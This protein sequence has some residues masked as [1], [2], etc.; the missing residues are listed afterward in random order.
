ME[1]FLIL[2]CRLAGKIYSELFKYSHIDLR[3]DDGGMRLKSGKFGKLGIGKLCFF[4][5]YRRDRK[6]DQDLI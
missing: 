6:G 4:I 2:I 1:K 3:K 5:I